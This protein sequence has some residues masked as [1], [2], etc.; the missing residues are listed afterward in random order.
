MEPLE[1]RFLLSADIIPFQVD[2]TGDASGAHYSLK[3]DNLIQAVQVFDDRSGMLIDSRSAQ[4]INFIRVVGTAANDRL[5]VDFAKEFLQGVEIDFEGGDGDDVLALTGGAFTDV[6]VTMTGDGAGAVAVSGAAGPQTIGFTGVGTVLDGSAAGNRIFRDATGQG[7]TLRIGDNGTVGDGIS[8]ID[9]VGAGGALTYNFLHPDVKLTIDAGAGDDTIV[10]DGFETALAGKILLSGGAGSDAVTGPPANT[11]WNITGRDSGSVS[12]VSFVEV[13]NLRG[14][15]DNEDT[16]FVSAGGVM[17]GVMDGGAG[18]FD[19]MVLEGNSGTIVYKADD[20]H[21]GTI[22]R[23][24]AVLTYAG[25]EPVSLGNAAN[26]TIDLSAA[27]D[28]AVVTM[29][30]STVTVASQSI[31]TFEQTSFE[32][33]TNSVTIKL[34][35]DQGLFPLLNEYL[36]EDVFAGANLGNLIAAF[37][38]GDAITFQGTI[39]LGSASL[40][41]D[42]EDGLDNIIVTGALTAGAIHFKAEEINVNAGASVSGT[43]VNFEAVGEGNGLIPTELTKGLYLA[44]PHAT[45]NVTGSVTATAGDVVM[46]ATATS[47]LTPSQ[48]QIGSIG[49]AIV[50]G[51]PKATITLGDGSSSA[52]ISATGKVDL[53]TAVNVTVTAAD[54]ADSSDTEAKLDAAIAVTT[55]ISKSEVGIFG[56]STIDAAGAVSIDAAS[57]FEIENVADGTAGGAG[58]TVAATVVVAATGVK[59][60]DSAS[61]GA[62]TA[63][64]SVAFAATT[65]STITTSAISTKG[66][67]DENGGANQSEQQLDSNNAKTA[68]GSIKF[69]GA[70]AVTVYRP[71]TQISSNTSGSI[72]SSGDITLSATTTDT[73]TSSADGSNTGEAQD[74]PPSG[75]TGVGVAVA[76]G[77]I[78]PKTLVSLGG[79]G[80]YTAPN[81]ALTSTLDADS[82]YRTEATSGV[83]DGGKTGFAGS[84]ALSVVTSTTTALIESDANVNLNGA[85]LTVSAESAT[86]TEASAKATVDGSGNSTGIGASV[87]ISVGDNDTIARISG[88]VSGAADITVSAKGVHDV[89]AAAEGGA[90]GGTAVTPV[91]ATAV[92]L[93]DTSADILAGSTLTITGDLTVTAEHDNEAASTANGAAKGTNA[94]IGASLALTIA[95]D[96]L[97]AGLARS[98]TAGGAVLIA[99]TSR[100]ASRADSKAS[101]TGA[102]QEGDN[103]GNTTQSQTNTQVAGAN[104]ASGASATAPGTNTSSGPLSVAA[105]IG[106]NIVQDTSSHAVIG[107]VSGAP[108]TVAAEGGVTV[109]SLANHDAAATADGKSVTTSNATAIGAAVAVNA[110]DSQ[111]HALIEH[112]IVT[113]DG[114]TVEAGMAEREIEATSTIDL[115]ADTIF[116]G[117]QAGLETGEKVVYS[118]GGGGDIGGLTSGTDYYVIKGEKGLIQLAASADDADN[119]VAVD[120]TSLGSGDAHKL[121]RPDTTEDDD[122]TFDPDAAR[123]AS[124]GVVTGDEVVY[125]NGGGGNTD[126]GGLTDGTTYFAIVDGSGNIKLAEDRAKALKGEAI[127]ITSSG[128]GDGHKLTETSHSTDATAKSGASKGKIGVAGSVAIN[129]AEGETS[130][131]FGDGAAVTAQDGDDANTDIGASSVKAETTTYTL[132]RAF[133]ATAAT[134]TTT[135]VGLSF[136][137]GYAGYD[138]LA[139]IKGSATVTANDLT[140][141]ADGGHGLITLATAGAGAGQGGTSVG[142]AIALGVSDNNTDARVLAGLAIEIEGDLTITAD[143]VVS[144]TTEAN[145]EVTG[146][147]GTGVG[148]AI[149]LGWTED[150]VGARLERSVSTGAAVADDVK[151]EA[152]GTITSTVLA[153]GSAEGEKNANS[154][155]QTSQNQTGSQ[156]SFLN[157]RTNSSLTEPTPQTQVASA[158]QTSQNQTTNPGGQG[159]ANANQA[160]TQTSGGVL[161]IAASI[162]GT[163]IVSKVAAEIADDVDIDASGD[164]SVKAISDADAQAE[165]VSIAFTKGSSSSNNVSA[166]VAFNVALMDTTARLGNGTTTAGS[167]TVEAG[168]SA[169]EVNAFKA[170][171]LS[172][173]GSQQSS[174]G[175]TTQGGSGGGGQGTGG[176]KSS[177]GIAGAVA[178]SVLGSPAT[179]DPNTVSASIAD[180]ATVT[181]L[182]GDVTVTARQDIGMQNIAGGGALRISGG[183][184]GGGGSDTTVGA[185]VTIGVLDVETLATIG[186]DATVTADTGNIDVSAATTFK[187]LEI[188]SPF[189]KAVDT[190]V[191]VTNLAIGA[192]IGSGGDT[193]AGSAVINVL[194]VTTRA[195]IGSGATVT[196]SAGDVSVTASSDVNVIDFAGS[197]AVTIGSGQKSGSGVGIGLDVTVLNETTEALVATR[198]GAATTVTAGGNVVV[199]ATSSEDF[200]QLTVNAGAGNSSSGAGGLNVL[201]ND[202]TTRALVGRDP[203]DAASTTGTAAIDADGSVVVAADSKTVIES[204]AGSLGVSLS[205]SAVGVSIGIVVDLDQ[206]TA[207]VGAGS[208]I[209]A[210]GGKTASVNDGIFDGDGNQGS[211]SVRG[212]AVTAISYGDVFLLAIAASG[213]L[214]SDNSGQGGGSGGSSS[215][216]GTKVGIAASVGVAVLKGETKATIGNGVAVNPDNTG[217]N[218]AQ[219]ILLRGAGETNLTNVTGGLTITLGG[220]DAGITGSV[221]V[222]EVDNFVW[223]SALGGNTLNAAGG[224]VR[225]DSHA[226]VDIDAVTIAVAGVVSTSSSSSGKNSSVNF[227]GAGAVTVNMVET[228]A[229]A[230]IGAGSAVSTTGDLTLEASDDS[231]ITADSGGVAITVSTNNGTTAG[232]VGAS[233]AVN[234]ITQTISATATDTSTS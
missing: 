5:T 36:G 19:S 216:G 63:P 58:A 84:L 159:N 82:T 149:A 97:L 196:A 222:N 132:T 55:L 59:F 3:Y 140:V 152:K 148:A 93:N 51:L 230:D 22:T 69:A 86:A 64:T 20:A 46:S 154:G 166:A 80:S 112:A 220:G 210:L 40:T 100:A 54:E 107:G 61:I 99:A 47:S 70:V 171:A 38:E 67:G 129:V 39:N 32:L 195:S 115:D 42:G 87:A 124:P 44:A 184:G 213:S 139:E 163:V 234:D 35:N 180:G 126:I 169:G 176:D 227:S 88:A 43:S 212:L 170:L 116:V 2:M 172:G 130:A 77:I 153:T 8:S 177:L 34:G 191:D 78:A 178:F 206:T 167:V 114:V 141:D 7:Q 6:T 155:G 128:T 27:S 101:A 12:G 18:G 157:A 68:E 125:S 10:H 95:Q 9:A 138:T 106:I 186:S 143:N 16:F 201:V 168:T 113:G 14:S 50:V 37:V 185:A 1:P 223:A 173:A 131:I 146:S 183:G 118:N 92:A 66:G 165:A 119:G 56:A 188:V 134:G 217:A 45:I 49:G 225:L 15:A 53:D 229:L 179:D 150:G 147:G 174:T 145:A 90:T 209:T 198:N 108:I 133:P 182:N 30:G 205:G 83:G 122:I 72:T 164:L 136:A 197:I 102:K 219:G 117:E 193:G 127:K 60:S 25:L 28:N 135:G 200:F 137:V 142:G 11:T 144:Q 65:T 203:T 224:G 208:T 160:G 74:P 109:K 110:S 199:D 190:G 218:A 151:V 202:T 24:G 187:P 33:P 13:E 120:L 162:G 48:G 31:P 221:T 98:V 26:V 181:A 89:L 215:S 41:V 156:T 194:D 4:E 214:G 189:V 233:V 94:A 161:R 211:E 231:A 121:Q 73:I 123:F 75:G 81:V 96:S 79:T 104:N 111:N 17:S 158:N 207:T 57:T 192:A 232:S 105:A 228:E 62:T 23:D 29:S 76:I 226:K 52:H 85:N 91:V 103:G 71:V 175:G 204:Y 21:S